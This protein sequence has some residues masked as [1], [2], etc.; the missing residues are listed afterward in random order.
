M[1]FLMPAGDRVISDCACSCSSLRAAGIP[2]GFEVIG[3]T[4]SSAPDRGNETLV[5]YLD[6][7]FDT[8]LA[9][10]VPRMF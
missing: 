2:V 6:E 8:H 10:Y 7:F 4:I 3:P 5:Q 1:I 9:T